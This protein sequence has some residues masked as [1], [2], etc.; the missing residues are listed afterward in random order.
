M[1]GA[2]FPARS[3]IIFEESLDYFFGKMHISSY[4]WHSLRCL[5]VQT[6]SRYLVQARKRGLVE[7]KRVAISA[8]A[9]TFPGPY[10]E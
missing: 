2:P 1:T 4:E 10:D 7:N 6:M 5:G 9:T 3:G 8:R